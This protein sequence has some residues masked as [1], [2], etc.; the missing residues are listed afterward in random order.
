[1]GFLE[2]LRLQGW[3]HGLIP[4]PTGGAFQGGRPVMAVS[5]L[6]PL[7]LLLEIG[8]DLTCKVLYHLNPSQGAK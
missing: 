3:A 4:G 1:M 5:T 6:L 7:T 8:L 2:G